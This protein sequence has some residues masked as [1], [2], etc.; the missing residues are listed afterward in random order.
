MRWSWLIVLAGCKFSSPQ[1]GDDGGVTDVARDTGFHPEAGDECFGSGFLQVCL[2]MPTTTAMPS[3][4][5]FTDGGLPCQPYTSPQGVQACVI[6]GTDIMFAGTGTVTTTG[7]KPLILVASGQIMIPAQATLDVASHRASPAVTGGGANSTLC[8]PGTAATASNGTGGGGYGGSFGGRGGDGGQ[9]ANGGNAGR[10]MLQTNPTTLRGGCPG[11]DGAQNGGGR[12]DGGGAVMLIANGMI[13]IDGTINAS[14]SAGIGGPN[15]TSRGG[16]GGGS[17]GM[18][19]LDA[20]AVAVAGGAHVFAN[21]AGGAEAADSF[22]GGHNGFDSPGP[23]IVPSGGANNTLQGGNGADGSSGNTVTGSK[24]NN[25]GSDFMG[26]DGGGGGGGGG[27]GVIFI[28]A[29]T[30]TGTTNTNNV[31]PPPGP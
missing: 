11:G 31:A 29:Q 2:K 27:A 8:V 4:A 6:A 14:G 12:G 18:I 3:G 5:I 13:K 10:A 22:A 7:T 23:A 21:G 1:V 9:G 28:F 25:G 17:G 15:S 19:V 16:G 20:P 24:G 30:K 26:N